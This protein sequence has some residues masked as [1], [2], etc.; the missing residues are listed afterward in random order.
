MEFRFSFPVH[1]ESE[2]SILNYP[3]NIRLVD[4]EKVFEI[5]TKSVIF[6]SAGGLRDENQI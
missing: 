1:T 4:G 2:L 3:Q 6:K 5:E